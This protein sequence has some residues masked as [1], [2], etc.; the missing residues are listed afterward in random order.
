MSP[1][2][3][4][5]FKSDELTVSA[6]LSVRP[7][8]APTV[9]VPLSTPPE[10]KGRAGGERDGAVELAVA[11]QGPEGAYADRSSRR[12][13]D[14]QGRRRRAGPVER[15][16]AVH[17]AAANAVARS[18]DGNARRRQRRSAAAQRVVTRQR[19]RTDRF[20]CPALFLRLV[21]EA[22]AMDE[23]LE[24][25][26]TVR[27]PKLTLIPPVVFSALSNWTLPVLPLV[28]MLKI[29]LFVVQAP[30]LKSVYPARGCHQRGGL[31]GNNGARKVGQFRR[32]CRRW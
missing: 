31:L 14:I 17:R 16:I 10:I 8:P 25:L 27:V 5:N 23:L 6:L 21:P 1:V 19:H 12:P 4:A 13:G 15:D 2:P 32:S 29:L 20:P 9:G 22:M 24:L 7:V 30:V 11:A 28:P 26:F 18:A 3:S